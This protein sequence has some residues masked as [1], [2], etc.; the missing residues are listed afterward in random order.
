[1]F[2][3]SYSNENEHN[4]QLASYRVCYN[5]SSHGFSGCG[6]GVLGSLV[7][8]VVLGLM[9]LDLQTPHLCFP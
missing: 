7:T 5:G 4:S 9:V 1:M 8:G 2:L 6:G 3:V